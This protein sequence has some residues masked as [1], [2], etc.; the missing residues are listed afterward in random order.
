MYLTFTVDVNGINVARSDGKPLE[1]YSDKQFYKDVIGGK[2]VAWQTLIDKTSKKTSLFLAVPIRNNDKIIG[3]MSS[4]M[5]IDDLSRQIVTWE[6]GDTGFAF[7]ADEKG[8]ILAHPIDEH[9]SKQKGLSRHPLITAFK[10]GQRGS[11]FFTDKVGRSFLGHVRK[12]TYGWAIARQQEEKEAY[13]ILGLVL[14][15]TYLLLGITIVFVFVIAWFSGRTMSRPIIDLTNAANRISIGEL[16]TEIKTKRKDEIG[17]LAE[18]ISRM[19]DSLRIS[20]EKL[21]REQ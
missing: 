9:I 1:D 3:A 10:N 4:L 19:Q 2:A 13:Y 12:T 15:F 18:A 7:L 6:G 11:I 14:S 8:R 16:D 17:D 20:I 21:R 5:R